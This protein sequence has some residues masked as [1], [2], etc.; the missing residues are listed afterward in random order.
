VLLLL[1]HDVRGSLLASLTP[2]ARQNSFFR[3]E[4][5]SSLTN[6]NKLSIFGITVDAM[7]HV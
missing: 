3:N 7:P 2:T 6:I 4:T 5:L 1:L